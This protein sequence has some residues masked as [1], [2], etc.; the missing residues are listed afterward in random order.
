MNDEA[1]AI[2][3]ANA[4]TPQELCT[5]LRLAM[6]TF[7]HHQSLGRYERFEVV[8]RIGPRR[9]SRK[10][11]QAYLDGELSPRAR[12]TMVGRATR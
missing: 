6:S 9:Y 11:V 5:K 8:P 4:M 12:P 10:L 7:Y 2:S 3:D 1:A